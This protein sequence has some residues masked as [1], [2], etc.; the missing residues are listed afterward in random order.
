M[1]LRNHFADVFKPH[2]CWLNV[3]YH[4]TLMF[5]RRDALGMEFPTQFKVMRLGLQPHADD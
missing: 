4:L 3:A 5:Y 2:A 1:A